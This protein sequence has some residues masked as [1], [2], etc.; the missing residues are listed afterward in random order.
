M[1]LDDFLCYGYSENM[2]VELYYN[3]NGDICRENIFITRNKAH[4]LVDYFG[5]FKIKRYY[6]TTT[7]RLIVFLDIDE[8]H[9]VKTLKKMEEDGVVE[10]L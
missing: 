2:E 4:Q 1:F 3:V 6:P 10:I 5:N 7:N 8:R 9:V